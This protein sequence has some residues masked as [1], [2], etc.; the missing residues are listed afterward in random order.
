MST[1]LNLQNV[2]VIRGG[3]PILN[4]VSW[5]VNEGER[6]VVLGPNGA[7]KSTLFRLRQPACT[8]P[9]ARL[10]SLTRPSALLTCSTCARALVCPPRFSYPDSRQREGFRRCRDRSVRC[11]RPLEGR[12][13]RHGRRSCQSCWLRGVDT[14]ADRTFGSSPTASASVH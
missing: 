5:T 12:I 3:R 2:S 4:N 14:L 7:G 11:V 1:V 6:W 9:A 10:R 13:R 8:R